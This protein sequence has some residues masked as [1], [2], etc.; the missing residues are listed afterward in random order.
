MTIRVLI[1]DD[2]A[3]VREGFGALLAAQ[4]DIEVAGSAANGAEAVDA[5]WRKHPDVVLMDV[6]MPVLDGLE[7]TRRILKAPATGIR[8]S[9][10]SRRSTWTTTCTRR[11]GPAPAASC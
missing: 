6:R 10:C 5:V 11:C 4:E 9:S 2:Q 8:A 3:M 1:V 7:A